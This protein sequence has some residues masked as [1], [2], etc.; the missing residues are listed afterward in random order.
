M[1]NDISPIDNT[2]MTVA[3][4]STD[5]SG[6]VFVIPLDSPL[7]NELASINIPSGKLYDRL[8]NLAHPSETEFSFVP[9]SG[10]EMILL[11]RCWPS[12]T[13][14]KKVAVLTELPGARYDILF[15][16]ARKQIGLRAVDW[17]AVA[18]SLVS[19]VTTLQRTLDKQ[20]W[21][22]DDKEELP[23]LKS[24]LRAPRGNNLAKADNA[25]DGPA[26]AAEDEDL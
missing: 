19:R 24:L 8:V 11:E 14:A 1:N 5:V 16:Q 13:V 21:E 23:T 25:L 3:V 10:Q 6:T 12:L 22:V 15:N 20:P 4:D 7:P 26:P 9:L 2:V 18:S 17:P